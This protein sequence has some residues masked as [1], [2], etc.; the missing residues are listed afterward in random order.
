M[1]RATAH[2]DDSDRARLQP[3]SAAAD[4]HDP[5][6]APSGAAP[7]PFGSLDA[8]FL[9]P[10]DLHLST[11]LDEAP[12]ELNGCGLDVHGSGGVGG[13]VD[14]LEMNFFSDLLQEVDYEAD[15]VSSPHSTTQ[16]SSSSPMDGRAQ[17]AASSDSSSNDELAVVAIDTPWFVKQ[18]KA[19]KAISS[20]SLPASEP[21]ELVEY[22]ELEPNDRKAKRRAQV[23]SSA[24]RL[25]CR[26]K[27]E[28]Q[29]LSQQLDALRCKHMQLRADGAL[30]AWEEKAIAQRHKRRQAEQI[31]EQLRRA[32]FLQS[33]FVRNLKSMFAQSVPC[34]VELNMRNFLHSPTHLREDPQSRIQDLKTVCTDAKLDM[35][36]QILLDETANIQALTTPNF[37]LQQL[38][39]G[40]QGFGMTTVAVYALE[41]TN[42]CNT[43][44][45]ACKAILNCGAVWPNYSLVTSSVKLAKLPPT[46]LNIRYGLS[47]NVYL[48]DTSGERVVVETRE[49]SYCRMTDKCGVFLWDY[50]DADDLHPLGKDTTSKCCTIGA[51]LVRP[52]ICVDGVE[53]VV[54]RNICSKVHMVDPSKVTPDIDRFAQSRHL[55]AR[56]CGSLVYETIK[57]DATM[58]TQ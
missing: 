26:K 30:A 56:I 53:R 48:S 52:E 44:K 4:D 39:L 35:A 8:E 15:A 42:A 49:V 6:L 22:S 7:L 46:K 13:Q 29:Y 24:R 27:T 43:F 51:V 58:S 33:G 45:V 21:Q 37:S 5:P 10:G 28:E 31:N 34:S 2:D 23:A 57:G 41:T 50:V 11:G 55:C 25:R 47:K 19:K 18:K 17:S 14:D 1:Q 12:L 40:S 32:L 20:T 16:S 36:M 38:D 9:A 54:C 3:L